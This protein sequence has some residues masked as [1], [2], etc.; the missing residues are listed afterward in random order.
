MSL[1]QI[2]INIILDVDRSR[3]FYVLSWVRYG[4]VQI[5]ENTINLVHVKSSEKLNVAA[6]EQRI[7]EQIDRG[8]IDKKQHLHLSIQG[9]LLVKFSDLLAKLYR[10][11]G[12]SSNNH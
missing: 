2:F 5:T 3:S 7:S 10:L 12:W 6:I 4:E 1:S 8:L 9:K 11:N